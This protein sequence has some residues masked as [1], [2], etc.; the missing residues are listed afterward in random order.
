MDCCSR[1][2]SRATTISLVFL[3]PESPVPTTVHKQ[4]LLPIDS[5]LTQYQKNKIIND[6]LIAKDPDYRFI[7]NN[8]FGSKHY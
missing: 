7:W 5:E 4:K 3:D 2:K 8:I 6:E 1:K